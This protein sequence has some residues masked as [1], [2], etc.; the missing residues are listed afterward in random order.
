MWTLY[1]GGLY[2]NY[3]G[4]SIMLL[5]LKSKRQETK[6][7]SENVKCAISK[8]GLRENVQHKRRNPVRKLRTQNN[9]LNQ[10]ETQNGIVH[11]K[12]VSSESIICPSSRISDAVENMSKQS[13]LPR[14]RSANKASACSFSEKRSLNTN[15]TQNI[16]VIQSSNSD[17]VQENLKAKKPHNKSTKK[18]KMSKEKLESCENHLNKEKKAL[19]DSNIM[20]DTSINIKTRKSK[21]NNTPRKSTEQSVMNESPSNKMGD[22][23]DGE[24]KTVIKTLNKTRKKSSHITCIKQRKK[25]NLKIQNKKESE[26]MSNSSQSEDPKVFIPEINSKALEKVNHSEDPKVFIPE[27]NLK[28]LEKVNHSEDP[29]VFIPEINSK[30]LEKVNHSEDPKVFIPEINSKAL[31]KVHHSPNIGVDSVKRFDS[32]TKNIEHKITKRRKK[33]FIQMKSTEQQVKTKV[34]SLKR[35]YPLGLD[36]NPEGSSKI[37]RRGSKRTI[38]K[39][40]AFW[41]NEHINYRCTSNGTYEIAGIVPGFKEDTI[42]VHP[43]NRKVVVRNHTQLLWRGP[44]GSPA[45]KKDPLKLCKSFQFSKY[46]MGIIVIDSL[47]EKPC[48]YAPTDSLFFLVVYGKVEVCIHNNSWIIETDGSFVVP[49]G[50]IYKIKNLRQDKAK[51]IFFTIM[52]TSPVGELGV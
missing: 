17:Q 13:F 2:S 25:V 51:L 40:V 35:P 6:L 43:K 41:R 11:K 14:L 1:S 26:K 45:K 31:E 39:P 32:I 21:I 24:N 8:P 46:S 49:L 47:Q 29:K 20:I 37:I 19:F 12:T 16:K 9:Q 7:K 18:T 22:K 27:I 48:H 23:T 52:G 50:N 5:Y 28:A 38:V 30:A 36:S 44:T 3:F 34:L 4:T 15:K 33:Q 10:D 42:F